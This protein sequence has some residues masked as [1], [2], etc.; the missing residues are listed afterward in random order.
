MAGLPRFP[1]MRGMTRKV[2]RVEHGAFHAVAGLIRPEAPCRSPRR[3]AQQAGGSGYGAAEVARVPW[4]IGAVIRVRAVSAR[5]AC[6]Q[7]KFTG[8]TTPKCHTTVSH[9]LVTHVCRTNKKS[10]TYAIRKCPTSPP[11]GCATSINDFSGRSLGL[12]ASVEKQVENPLVVMGAPVSAG[13]RSADTC[14]G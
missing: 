8:L 2:G 9:I 5:G 12:S 13:R 7:A 1:L 4:R 3:K 6:T 14:S 10:N 11:V